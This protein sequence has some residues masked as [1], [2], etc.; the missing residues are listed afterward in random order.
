M[1]TTFHF[2]CNP[3]ISLVT[4]SLVGARVGAGG[5]GTALQAARSPVRLEFFTD[6]ILP[7]VGSTRLL[8]YMRTRDTFGWV[9]TADA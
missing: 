5:S 2:I 6:I 7:A 3:D 9:K 4:H 1:I 8:T